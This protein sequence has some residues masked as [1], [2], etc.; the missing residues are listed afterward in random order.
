MRK[1]YVFLLVFSISLMTNSAIAQLLKRPD[2]VLGLTFSTS[3]IN[4]TASLITDNSSVHS[5]YTTTLRQ[6]GFVYGFRYN[7]LKFGFGSVSLGSPLMAGFSSTDNYRSVDFDGTKHDTI[8]G[9]T[10]LN[11]ACEIPVFADLNLGLYSAE[12]ESTKKRFGVYIGVGYM[13][14]YTRIHTSVGR[15]NYDGF[16]PAVRAG[17]RMGKRW[18]SRWSIGLSMRA[19]FTNSGMRTY[20]LQV[21]KEL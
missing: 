8:T 15:A 3:D 14:S 2:Q 9:I 16:E 12:D 18:E 19:G 17:I 13:Y 6:Y 4:R 20:G 21:M 11:F 5:N 7:I 10:G 1:L